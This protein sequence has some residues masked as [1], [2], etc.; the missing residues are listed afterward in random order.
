GSLNDE[1]ERLDAFVKR[2]PD[3]A[4][5]LY[6]HAC[7]QMESYAFDEAARAFAAPGGSVAEARRARA[8]GRPPPARP[9]LP[10]PL[11]AGVAALRARD[12]PR[13]RHGARFPQGPGGVLR[14][15]RAGFGQ[16]RRPGRPLP[17][18]PLLGPDRLRRVR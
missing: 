7:L 12:R 11:R 3:F 6:F 2:N 15:L 1:A 16:E 17:R 9:E 18:L 13:Q 14:D 4:S 10:A 8:G 5:G